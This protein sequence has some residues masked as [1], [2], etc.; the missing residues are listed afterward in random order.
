MSVSWSEALARGMG[1]TRDIQGDHLNNVTGNTPVYIGVWPVSQSGGKRAVSVWVQPDADIHIA[2]D[3]V[4]NTTGYGSAVLL[5]DKLYIFPLAPQVDTFC[6]LGK[7]GATV[8]IEMVW[9]MA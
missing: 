7:A 4:A 1:I 3:R 6:F 5:A 9:V 8:N 2:V